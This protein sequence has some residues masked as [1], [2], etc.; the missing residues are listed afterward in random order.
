MAKQSAA[1]KIVEYLV[2]KKRRVLQMQTE[3]MMADFA[4]IALGRMGFSETR[5]KRFVELLE[6]VHDEYAE[7]LND[8]VKNDPDEMIY[9]RHKIEEELEHYCKGSYVPFEKRYEFLV[10]EK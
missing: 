7:L 5:L 9:S 3:Q 6:T 10:K 2:E 4:T 8:D 1:A